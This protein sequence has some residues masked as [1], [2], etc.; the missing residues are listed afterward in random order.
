MLGRDSLS[1]AVLNSRKQF[2]NLLKIETISPSHH[3]STGTAISKANDLYT[4]ELMSEENIR[5]RSHGANRDL[6]HT[7]AE[8]GIW[9]SLRERCTFCDLKNV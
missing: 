4:N 5:I 1:L 6:W 3:E 2:I 9:D 8:F 7:L